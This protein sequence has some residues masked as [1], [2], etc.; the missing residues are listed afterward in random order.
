MYNARKNLS[1]LSV[2]LLVITNVIIS[3]AQEIK[4]VQ[5]LDAHSKTVYFDLEKGLAVADTEE[6]WDISLN[7]TTIALYPG[8]EGGKGVYAKVLLKPFDQTNKADAKDG[9]LKDQDKKLAIPTGSGN[10]W[11]EYD[12]TDHAINPIKDHVII[13]KTR[14]GKLYKLEILNYYH[15]T[16]HSSANYTF[17]YALLK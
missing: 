1:Y 12:M 10:G 4:T 5:N 7:K 9:L 2:I 6:G 15:A 11:Y 8:T 14:T 3:H 16:N 17:R 13:V